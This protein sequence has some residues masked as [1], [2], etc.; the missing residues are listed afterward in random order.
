MGKSLLSLLTASA[1]LLTGASAALDPIVIK[2]C[3]HIE[4]PGRETS[5]RITSNN[6][7]RAASSSTKPMA[8]NSSSR[9]LRINQASRPPVADPPPVL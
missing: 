8:L 9:A 3:A 6:H 1:V 7:L 2:V 4:T 5:H